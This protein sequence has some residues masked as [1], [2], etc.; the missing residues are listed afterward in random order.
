M[1]AL[2]RAWQQI[3]G[4]GKTDASERADAAAVV[5]VAASD[6]CWRLRRFGESV[7]AT[8]RSLAPRLSDN[9][10][11]EETEQTG[12]TT[13]PAE[14]GRGLINAQW[15]IVGTHIDKHGSWLAEI[16]EEALEQRC[17]ESLAT[18]AAVLRGRR[19]ESYPT[20]I[21]PFAATDAD[22]GSKEDHVDRQSCPPRIAT[23]CAEWVA[24]AS[25]LTLGP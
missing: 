20:T 25:K 4:G 18:E 3:G 10:A 15:V 19:G 21:L 1:A 11:T 23:S 12:L 5:A 7:L 8:T 17:K 14:E 9:F 2:Q 16:W 6:C 22:Q 13:G 24:L